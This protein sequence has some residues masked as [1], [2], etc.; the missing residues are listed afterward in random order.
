MRSRQGT[1][2]GDVLGALAPPYRGSTVHG[3]GFNMKRKGEMQT[4]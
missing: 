3:K 4:T 1:Q 2:D